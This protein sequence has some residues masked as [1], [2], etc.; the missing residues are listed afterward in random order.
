MAV[1]V[2]NVGQFVKRELADM[3][4]DILV[5]SVAAYVDK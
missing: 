3:S 5:D 4:T 2:W 1:Y